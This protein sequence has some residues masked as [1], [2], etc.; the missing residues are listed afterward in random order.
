M[1]R[2]IGIVCAFIVVGLM[3]LADRLESSSVSY[4]G[5]V[6]WMLGIALGALV[7]YWQANRT[8]V[9]PMILLVAFVPFLNLL[10][11]P[12]VCIVL[13]VMPSKASKKPVK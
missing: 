6:F 11:I 3:L 8:K 10:L 7:I 5:T 1:K 9:S 12:L 4:L 13:A 2:I